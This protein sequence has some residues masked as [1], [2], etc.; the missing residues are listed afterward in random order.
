MAILT[1]LW[2]PP[3]PVEHFVRA[4][5]SHL[6]ARAKSTAM[7]STKRRSVPSIPIRRRAST[8]SPVWP[9][10]PTTCRGDTSGNSHSSLFVVRVCQRG[11]TYDVDP[12]EYL[13][14][15]LFT[16]LEISFGFRHE[17]KSDQFRRIS[18]EPSALNLR[19]LRLKNRFRRMGR[20][21]PAI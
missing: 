7:R 11:K 20:Q 3:L 9:G 14:K 16:K 5:P 2:R 8:T 4:C 21:R 15:Q 18:Y 10:R 6:S 1:S 19:Q 12:R 13:L 17:L